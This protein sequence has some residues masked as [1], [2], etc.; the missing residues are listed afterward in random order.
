MPPASASRAGVTP[1]PSGDPSSRTLGQRKYVALPH[2]PRTC[3]FL[4]RWF[5]T[6]IHLLP[7][8]EASF[9]GSLFDEWVLGIDHFLFCCHCNCRCRRCIDSLPILAPHVR[10]DRISCVALRFIW[11][12][13]VPIFPKE[14]SWKQIRY[15]TFARALF[16]SSSL[17]FLRSKYE[18]M[19]N[20][21]I[22]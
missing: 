13:C 2:H 1:E 19:H 20:T 15:L 21:E 10:H 6:S 18:E 8:Q 16:G 3:S 17:C 9:S 4:R 7:L 12:D 22:S 5:C 14:E 11:M